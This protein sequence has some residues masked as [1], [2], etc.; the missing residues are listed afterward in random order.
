MN[1]AI[2]T[3]VLLIAFNRPDTTKKVFQK[4]RE[5]KPTKLFVAVDGS[6]DNKNG[7]AQLVEQVKQIVK[8]V[9]WDCEI[10]YKFNN[11]NLGAEITVSSAISW[12]LE[13][14]ESVIVLEDDIIAPLSFFR[15]A[16]EML[17]K[18]KYEEN[19]YM[20]SSCNQTPIKLPNSEDY[21]FARYGHTW[22]WATW[23]RAWNSFDLY[24]N[25]FDQYLKTNI[26]KT[27]TDTPKEKKSWHHIINRMKL[28]GPGN[29]NWDYCWAY[30]KFKNQGLNI[31]PR[32][33]IS[34]NIGVYGLHARG[35]TDSHYRPYD[36][37]FIVKK[38]P[39]KVERNIEYDKHHFKYYINKKP[40]LV[41]RAIN[42]IKRILKSNK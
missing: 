18:Y 19:V 21:L 14:E 2:L 31:V 22:G 17:E 7:E 1:T 23:K 33:H 29:N 12:V 39:Q 13:N 37:D 24:V 27:L 10:N 35:Q 15:F 42:K 20:I 32:N 9:D 4:I 28:K 36:E 30:I 40:H 5:V 25:D 34:S 6:R 8:Q 11:Y 16:Q 38:H 41:K 3:P 26:L